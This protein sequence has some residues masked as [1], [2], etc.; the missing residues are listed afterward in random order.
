MSP[1]YGA[2]M[3]FFP[4]D[5]QSIEYLNL[6]GRE[7]HQVNVIQSYLKEQGLYRVYDGSQPDP[8]YSGDIME[9]DL[10][11]VVPCLSG[12]KRPHDRVA[13]DQMQTDFKACLTNPVG[14]KG[15]GIGEDKLADSSKIE[16]TEHEL[17]HG[18]VVIAAITSCTNTSNPSVMIQSGLVAKKA[19]EKGLT[20]KPYIK[21]SLS[22]GSGV[23]TDYF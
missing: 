14:F 15:F 18:S 12:P 5:D 11:S 20:T 19:I 1:E 22:P 9:L 21:T 10:A 7:K 4:V 2:T 17:K 8:D 16:G 23:V 6:I 13:M 3:G